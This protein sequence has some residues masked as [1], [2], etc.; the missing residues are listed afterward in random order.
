MRGCHNNDFFGAN[1]P[2]QAVTDLLVSPAEDE[3]LCPNRAEDDPDLLFL[4]CKIEK[5]FFIRICCHQNTVLYCINAKKG[6]LYS[7]TVR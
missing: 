5:G 3:S 2:D 6:F 7:Q 4:S 1:P